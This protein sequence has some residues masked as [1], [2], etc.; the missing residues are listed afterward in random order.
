MVVNEV[1]IV[2]VVHGLEVYE[3]L[4]FESYLAA[5]TKKIAKAKINLL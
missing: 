3:N 1:C 4:N 5:C 2:G